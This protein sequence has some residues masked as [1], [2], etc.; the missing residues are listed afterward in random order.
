MLVVADTSPIHVL[1][2]IGHI[3]V[4]PRLFGT[5]LIP[6][7]VAEELAHASY[8][9]VR[10]FMQSLPAWIEVREPRNVESIPAIHVGEEAAISLARELAADVLLI[11]DFEGRKAASNRGVQILGT[12]GVLERAASVGLIELQTALDQ[13][14]QTDFRVSDEVIQAILQRHRERSP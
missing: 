4:L 1:V 7:V 13:I 11:D 3:E 12:L 9:A 10:T 8:E 5:I 14:R 6:T 2:R